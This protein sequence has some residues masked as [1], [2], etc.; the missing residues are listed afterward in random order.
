MATGAVLGII[1]TWNL[2]N[3]CRP[4]PPGSPA[5]ANRCAAKDEPT[6]EAKVEALAGVISEIG[7]D[8]LGVQEV[9]SLEALDDLVRKLPGTWHTAVSD[10]PDGRGIR[11]GVIS[12]WPLLDIQQRVAFPDHLG[13]VQVDDDGSTITEMGRGALSVRV[14]P[15][16]GRSVHVAVCHLKSKLLTFPGNQHSTHDEGLRARYA[17][18]AL[19]RR[20]AEAVIMRALADELLQGD[21]KSRDIVVL[22]DFNDDWQAA[23]TQI[24]YGPA[25]LPDRHRRLRP[26]RPGRRKAAVEPGPAHPGTRRLLPHLR[27]PA[28][29]HRPHPDQPL[30]A[31]GIREGLH[32]DQQAA[33][34]GGHAA[35]RAARQA[36][37]PLTRGGHVQSLDQHG[38]AA[39]R[40][41]V[42]RDQASQGVLDRGWFASFTRHPPVAWGILGSCTCS[43]ALVRV[44]VSLTGRGAAG[45]RWPA[46]GGP[47]RRVGVAGEAV[48][49]WRTEEFGQSHE[50]VAGAVL[51]DGSEPKP[52][53]LDVGSGSAGHETSEWWAY[54]GIMRRPKAAA[55]RGSCSC[56]WRGQ[57]YPIDWTQ[58]KDD[59]LDELDVSGPY[60][61]WLEHIRTVERQTVPLPAD[62]AQVMDQLEEHLTALAEQAPAAALKAVARLERLAVSAGREAACAAEADELSPETIGKALGVSAARARSRMT[63]YLLRP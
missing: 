16:P 23:T 1:G 31:G 56:G 50:G 2:E 15:A 61:D 40:L 30:P 10:H 4:L 52:V 42:S 51:A 53:Y 60:D 20:G 27:G 6:Y 39:C 26:P 3:F 48:M 32:R 7:P 29:A 14:E 18:Y 54:D 9:G 21:G 46:K 33:E 45:S 38:Q 41:G 44:A 22:G 8:L 55:V 5:S 35:G 49:G 58:M 36:F 63:H 59:R 34:R 12:R 37:R 28:R 19:F 11:V 13:Q 43:P 62:L 47:V 25:R 17:A 57:S 24:L